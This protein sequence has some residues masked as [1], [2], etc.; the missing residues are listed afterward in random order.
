M[1]D[2]VAGSKPAMELREGLAR[3]TH[4]VSQAIQGSLMQ[5]QKGM[6]KSQLV[7]YD[8]N[9][10]GKNFPLNMH[11]IRGGKFC[12][13][14]KYGLGMAR[15]NHVWADVFRPPGEIRSC[16]HGMEMNLVILA[17]KYEINFIMKR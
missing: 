13:A 1:V 10:G 6:M 17:R 15:D 12:M 9:Y 8:T 11:N 7:N 5:P 2:A 3:D 14:Q 4:R 16:Q